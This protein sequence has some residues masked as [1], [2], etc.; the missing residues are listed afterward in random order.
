[1]TYFFT[2]I[3]AEVLM[4]RDKL[5]DLKY[6][7]FY[8]EFENESIQE[9]S[10][11]LE[12][13]I[14]ERGEEDKGVKNGLISLYG[15]HFN[16]LRAL[17]SMGASLIELKNFY[18][19]SVE[20]VSKVWKSKTFSYVQ[21]LWMFSIGIML[22]IEDKEFNKLVAL[23][24]RDGLQDYLLDIL[25]KY[26]NPN[27]GKQSSTFQFDT[28]YKALEKVI[29]LSPTNKQH[30]I[31][32]LKYYLDKEWYNGHNDAAWYNCH[33]SKHDVYSGYWSFESGAL[34]KILDL[35]DSILKHQQYYPY[36]MVHWKD[37]KL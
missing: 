21:L 37:S 5:K 6:F 18:Y 8:L 30:A 4:I 17:Y 35:D 24:E 27:W 22:E 19:E 32:G 26:R 2:K 36:D 9:F 13:L 15:F 3:Y 23:I 25:I 34:V 29:E 11:D 28:P 31:E 16:K 14:Q 33:E 7:E 10:V 12:R 1:M 20:I